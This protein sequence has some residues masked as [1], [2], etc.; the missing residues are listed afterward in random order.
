M[1]RCVPRNSAALSPPLSLHPRGA[2]AIAA[3]RS[4]SERGSGAWPPAR[5]PGDPCNRSSL[6]AG[7]ADSPPVARHCAEVRV[8]V[9]GRG[10]SRE[11]LGG[12][13]LPRVGGAPAG[14]RHPPRRQHGAWGGLGGGWARDRARLNNCAGGRGAAP[15]RSLPCT[16]VLGGGGGAGVAAPPRHE[17]LGWG[18]RRG[19]AGPPP[20]AMGLG[21]PP[22]NPALHPAPR[23]SGAGAAGEPAGVG[24]WGAGLWVGGGAPPRRDPTPV[25]WKV[26]AD[27]GGDQGAAGR[28]C[29]PH[30][31]PPTPQNAELSAGHVGHQRRAG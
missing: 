24:A 14:P 28:L 22:P 12:G 3:P 16:R 18:G 2:L 10:L 4:A 29:A 19:G 1:H 15:R 6:A 5:A 25:A 30:P 9:R 7:A 26:P 27:E 23:G 11:E 17:V 21:S 31:H 8:G 20:A 13:A